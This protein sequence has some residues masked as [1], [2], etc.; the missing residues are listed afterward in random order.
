[1]QMQWQKC[2]TSPRA[3]IQTLSVENSFWYSAFLA[4]QLRGCVSFAACVGVAGALPVSI[5]RFRGQTSSQ[6]T[7]AINPTQ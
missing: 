2:N 1:M 4:I 3:N 6:H 5:K 7:R